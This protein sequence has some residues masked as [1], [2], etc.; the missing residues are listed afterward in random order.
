MNIL[1][2]YISPNKTTEKISYALRDRFIQD[3]HKVTTLNI[4]N[5]TNRNPQN[6]SP[7]IFDEVDLIGIG[8]PAY[9]MRIL[10]PM[11][12]FLSIALPR[13]KKPVK[14][15]I[16]LAFGGITTGK[17]FLNTSKI[18][19]QHAI[20]IVGGMKVWAPHFYNHVSY[21]DPSALK[22]ID[23][24]CSRLSE[25][26][27]QSIPWEKV[28][29]MFSYQTWQVNAVYPLTHWIGKLRQ[30][31][32]RIDHNKCIKCKRCVNECP[33]GAME[34]GET[35]IHNSQKC[36]YCY[37]CTTVC[38]RQAILCPT[39]KVEDMLRINKKIIGCEQPKNAVFL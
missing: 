13:L 14:A 26:Q 32:I 20:S 5:Q 28:K 17:A 27:F 33:T 23:L 9:H 15:F 37:H 22:T 8:S 10:E 11:E 31:P 25:N 21:P 24:F 2:L 34:M 4:G 39:E 36:I 7:Q 35:V 29:Q 19:K 1:L 30:L 3:G 6:L 38:S 12:N 18:L 16:Y